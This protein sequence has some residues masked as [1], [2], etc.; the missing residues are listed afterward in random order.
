M[1]IICYIIGQLGRAG[2]ERQLYELVNGINREKFLPIVISLSQGGYWAQE[3]RKNN[4]QVIEIPRKKS[5]EIARLFK[6]IKLLKTI[7]PQVVHT[8]L[9]PGNFYGRIAAIF[10]RVPVI[11]SSERNL[12]E[13]G[14]D[15]NILQLLIDK[16]LLIFTDAIICNSHKA[17]KFLAREYSFTS[18]KLFTVHNGICMKEHAKIIS[19]N[20]SDKTHKI[21]G[22]VGR[23]S[24]QKNYVLFLEMA[25]IILERSRGNIQFMIVGDGP[26]KDELMNY[27]ERIGIA[28]NILFTGERSDISELLQGMD[29]FV[30]T[31]L[32]EGLSNSI[33]EAMLSG[34]PVVATDVGGNDEL[35]IDKVTGFLCPSNNVSA[36]SE[37]VLHLIENESEA[38]LMGEKGKNKMLNEFQ[39]DKMVSCT[40]Q[41]YMDLLT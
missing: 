10:T 7:K 15:K 32:Y 11:I 2:A 5:K 40:E 36:L 6:L 28:N 17:R 21:I 30:M 16:L 23:L 29:I 4:I 14:K 39:I 12:P 18:G 33:M 13:V 34:L 1:T 41:I 20:Y 24:P 22:T 26:L 3:I 35:I 25:K 38:I 8:Y 37:A 27:A 31:S 19:N 9:F